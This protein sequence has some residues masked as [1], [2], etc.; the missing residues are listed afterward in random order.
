[1]SHVGH[2]GEVTVLTRFGVHVQVVARTDHQS[3]CTLRGVRLAQCPTRYNVAVST[4]HGR[5]ASQLSV[6]VRLSAERYMTS[7]LLPFRVK[8]VT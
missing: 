7:W 2:R 4:H 3:L 1:M 5:L 8:Q 6:N